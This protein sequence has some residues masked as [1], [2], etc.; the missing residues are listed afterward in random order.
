M[1][2]TRYWNENGWFH[3]YPKNEF[4]DQYKSVARDLVKVS[5]PLLSMEEI[6]MAID[7]SI[8]NRL[9]DHPVRVDNNY[10]KQEVNMTLLAVADYVMSRR[11]IITSYGVM[12][13]RHGEVPNPIYELI[14]S[15]IKNRKKLKKEMFKYPKGSEMFEKYNL[16]QLLS[17]ISWSL[18]TVM[19]NDKLFNCWKAKSRNRYANQQPSIDER[20]EF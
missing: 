20:N 4:I 19:Y 9:Q 5:F 2:M 1:D 14:D 17:K 6:D 10:K 3:N 16:L 11:P 15:F 12:F 13:K 8:S 7:W 18:Y